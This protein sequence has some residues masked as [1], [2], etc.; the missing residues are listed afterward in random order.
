MQ[1]SPA[2]PVFRSFDEAKARAFYIDYL[3]FRWDGDHRFYDGA[4][5]YAFLSRGPLNLHLSEHHG[6]C[7]PGSTIMVNVSDVQA[8]LNDLRSRNHPNMN[9]DLEELPWGVQ[10]TVTD[11]FGNRIRFLQSDTHTFKNT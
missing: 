2:T 10:I 7:T 8:I 6:D 5:V 3:G 1:I 9:P 4:P 11:P